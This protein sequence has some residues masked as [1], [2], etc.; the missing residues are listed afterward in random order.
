MF[1]RSGYR[2]AGC[3]DKEEVKNP[4]KEAP[5][6]DEQAKAEYKFTDF[7]LDV[8]LSDTNDAIDAGYDVEKKTTEASIQDKEQNINL[9][10]DEA[11]KELDKKFK[12]FIFDEMTPDAEVL[13]EVE[14]A[15]S[16]PADAKSVEVEITYAN[17]TE[18]EYR[19]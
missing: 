6:T 7:G 15:F 17:G 2:L 12:D 14:K 19:R 4:P 10:G 1:F 5:K 9:N 13:E 3:S 18:K 8:D 16:V 11:M